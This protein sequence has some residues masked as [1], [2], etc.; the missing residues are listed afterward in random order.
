MSRIPKKEQK[1]A[2]GRMHSPMAF[3]TALEVRAMNE[4]RDE[5]DNLICPYD[6]CKTVIRALTGLQELNKMRQHFARKH[7]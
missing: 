7:P 6:G 2:S 1:T 4:Q 5:Y 3:D